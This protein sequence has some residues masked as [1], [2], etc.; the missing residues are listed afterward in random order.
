MIAELRD[1]KAHEASTDEAR[2]ELQRL[3]EDRRFRVT[4]RQKAILTYLAENRLSG[5]DDSVKAYAIALDVLGRSSDFDATIDPIV[6][7]EISRLRSALDS[8]YEAFGTDGS[9]TIR[10]PKGSYVALFPTL[11]SSDDTAPQSSPA[12][13]KDTDNPPS[14]TDAPAADAPKSFLR[15]LYVGITGLAS[16]TIA[17]GILSGISLLPQAPEII[18]KPVVFLSLDA[19]DANLQGEASQVRDMLMVALTGFTTVTVAKA[20]Y[21]APG[22]DMSNRHQY[23]VQLKYYDAGAE[24]AVWWQ[25]SD[26]ETNVILK[27]GL[28]Q[29]DI[30]GRQPPSIREKVAGQLASQLAAS[31]G[32]INKIETQRDPEGALGNT[33]VIR[34]ETALESG[35]QADLSSARICLERTL[36]IAANDP[37]ATAVMSRVMLAGRDAANAADVRAQ[38][39]QLA[40]NA[41]SSTPLSD[42]AQTALMVAHLANG[43]MDAALEAGNRA[44]ELNPY[45][46]E[47]AAKL[48]FILY[49]GSYRDA[50]IAMAQ[51]LQKETDILPADAMLVL[52]LDAYG[53]GRYSEASLWSEQI[54]GTDLLVAMLRAASMGQLNSPDA[55]ERLSGFINAAA[56]P[57][58]NYRNGIA[59]WRNQQAITT[60]LTGGLIKAG[61]SPKDI[62]GALTIPR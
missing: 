11:V 33:C 40:R 3:F 15:P 29:I 43:C 38:A 47:A 41:I 34:A 51:G 27:S 24:R 37:D 10:I 48:A 52:A 36:A 1:I 50:A 49:L 2:Q 6:R 42:R 9:T 59:W 56:R 57:A 16:A 53:A 26:M 28:E 4:E 32:I 5:S 31:R 8:Y 20:G 58:A 18:G 55:Y 22:L 61:V 21:S 25:I 23:E 14:F 44:L 62:S 19:A 17:A 60:E 30:S 54:N 35:G 7:I 13:S 45:N 39:L 46:S 12:E